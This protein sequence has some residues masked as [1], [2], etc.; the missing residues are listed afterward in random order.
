MLDWRYMC[1]DARLSRLEARH[2]SPMH[3][4]HAWHC[5][6]GN[7]LHICKS[8]QFLHPGPYT[9]VH[10]GLPGVAFDGVAGEL[11]FGEAL[12]LFPGPARVLR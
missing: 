11:G 9:T 8:W 5:A 7:L 6:E 3:P 12:L 4:T 10:H 2:K 1:T